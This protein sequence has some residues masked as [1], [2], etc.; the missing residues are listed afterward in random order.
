MLFE[1]LQAN[2][3]DWADNKGLLKKENAPKQFLKV[4]EEV[5]ELAA[6]VA[7][8]DEHETID[9]MGDTFVTL[10]ILSAQLGYDPVACLNEA[11]N[12]IA[13]RT[14]KTVNGVFIKDND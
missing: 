13:K 6:A 9:A 3:E 7:R 5:G 14:G 10:I 1:E 2:V 11:Y 4:I 8:D 12:V